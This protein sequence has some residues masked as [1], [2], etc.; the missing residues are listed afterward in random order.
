MSIYV[1]GDI[2][3][4][5][6][7]NLDINRISPEFPFPVWSSSDMEPTVLQPGGA[8]NLTYQF[9]HIEKE[10]VKLVGIVDKKTKDIL[11]KRFNIDCEYC[12]ITEGGFN[13]IK[14]RFTCGDYPVGRWDIEKP[15]YGLSTG[16]ITDLLRKLKQITSNIKDSYII[17]S[18]YNK[19]I[20]NNTL[21][22][23]ELLKNNEMTFV[24]PKKNPKKWSGAYLVK[25]NLQEAFGFAGYP[26]SLVYSDHILLDDVQKLIDC[27]NVV[28][29]MEGRGVSCKFGKEYYEYNDNK[30]VVKESSV[31]AGD[32]FLAIIVHCIKSGVSLQEA[33]VIAFKCGQIYVGKKHNEP[34]TMSELNSIKNPGRSK[35]VSPEELS[36]R[37]YKLVFTNGVWD[38]IHAQ[39]IQLLREAKSKGDKLVV[40]V[41]SDAS[42]KKLKGDKRPIN[43]L[44]DRMKVLASLQDVD[45]VISFDEDTPVDIIKQLKPDV[46]CKGGDYKKEEVVGYK[47]VNGN[48][49]IFPYVEGYSSTKIINAM[50]GE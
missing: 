35:F 38:I 26:D 46:L 18:D 13:P 39:H 29:T 10:S 2:L 30:R 32:A 27:K 24:D 9:K 12:V 14:K 7:H 47:E 21:W 36:K 11:E 42:V 15:N 28:I 48:V 37:D 19:G 5:H 23:N 40:A 8:A 41:N 22:F 43:K 49:Y 45:Y 44:E 50:N 16:G 6:Y 20:L 25:P 34:L 1:V 17:F 31:G 33:S 3:V 4:D